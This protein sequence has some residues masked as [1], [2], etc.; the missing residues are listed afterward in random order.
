MTIAPLFKLMDW[1]VEKTSDP[2][3]VT[4]DGHEYVIFEQLGHRLLVKN[5]EAYDENFQH[6]VEFTDDTEDFIQSFNKDN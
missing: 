4:K 3:I 1:E 2:N 6:L 5:K